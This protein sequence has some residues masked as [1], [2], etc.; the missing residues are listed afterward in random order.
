MPARQADGPWTVHGD[1]AC[2]LLTHRARARRR[3]TC[4]GSTSAS[5][6]AASTPTSAAPGSSEMSPTARQQAQYDRWRRDH[7]RGPRRSPAP[8]DRVGPHGRRDRRA[9][10]GD[11]P[12]MSHF[13]LGH[14]LGLDSAETPYVGTDLGDGFDAAWSSPPAWCWCS[15]RSCG[16]RATAATGPRTCS[17]SPKTAGNLSRLPVRPVWRL[18]RV[19]DHPDAPRLARRERALRRDGG[20]RPRRPRARAGR[21]HPLR[22]GRAAAV[23]RRH[24]RRSARAAWSCA[25]PARSTC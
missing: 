4:S 25:P 11:R 10:G 3:A 15:S 23:E 13:Y 19:R 9:A 1:L 5:A 2:P 14:G 16:T 18:S 12:W 24:A 20:S 6:T 7:R 17:S 21:Q 22:V 8:G